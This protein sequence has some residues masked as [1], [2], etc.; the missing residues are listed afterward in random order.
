MTSALVEPNTALVIAIALSDNIASPERIFLLLLPLT[1]N[2]QNLLNIIKD[3]KGE[4]KILSAP[5]AND[6]KAEPHKR[7]WVKKN[8]AFFPP[9][10][11]I[12]S[13]DKYKWAKQPD[14]TP[15]ILID[16]FGKNVDAWEAAGGTGFKYKD[17][18]FERT[19]KD[20][21]QHLNAKVHDNMAENFADG[22]VKGKSKPGR[23]KKSGA[24]CNGSVTELRAKA[25]KASGE[26]AKMYHWCANMKSGRS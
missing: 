15:N 18:K 11:V 4:Y 1:N 21:Q 25:K 19:A 3:L 22:K 20:L 16:D 6:P 24:S 23:V 12:I 14:G 26:R 8:L 7:E 17:H 13:A 2:A 9:K 10:E 5:L